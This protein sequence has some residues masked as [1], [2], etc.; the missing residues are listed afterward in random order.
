M[1]LPLI[2]SRGQGLGRVNSLE[3]LILHRNKKYFLKFIKL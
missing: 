1:L 2:V 3:G